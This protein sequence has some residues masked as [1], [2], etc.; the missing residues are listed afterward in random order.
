MLEE[1][2]FISNALRPIY[3]KGK[4]GF[5]MHEV[6]AIRE[7]MMEGED[8]QAHYYLFDHGNRINA[9]TAR[10]CQHNYI[11]VCASVNIGHYRREYHFEGARRDI[12]YLKESGVTIFQIDSPYD[13]FF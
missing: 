4:Y 12:Q 7:R 1:T 6:D 8:I 10:W 5:R 11:E 9:E 13:E 2:Y 3:E